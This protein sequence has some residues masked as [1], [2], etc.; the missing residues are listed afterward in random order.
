[1]GMPGFGCGRAVPCMLQ[2]IPGTQD[3]GPA[4]SRAGGVTPTAGPWS[5]GGSFMRRG[6]RVARPRVFG[7]FT[8]NCLLLPAYP[9]AEWAARARVFGSFT[10]YC[11]LPTAYSRAVRAARAR[12]I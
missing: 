12:V 6:V 8:A 5:I 1:M 3:P 2:S 7:V 10:A 11:L 9:R 4:T